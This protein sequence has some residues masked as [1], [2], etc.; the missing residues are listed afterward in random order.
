MFRSE[1]EQAM[2]KDQPHR[3]EYPHIV[4]RGYGGS[5]R[6]STLIHDR[7]LAAYETPYAFIGKA[8]VN[9]DGTPTEAGRTA[10]MERVATQAAA[11]RA[12]LAIVW[13]ASA[14]TYILPDGTRREGRRPPKGVVVVDDFEDG[15]PLLHVE[16]LWAL[17]LPAGSLHDHLCLK[18]TGDLVEIAPGEPMVVADF[19]DGP[20]PG[21]SSP[22]AGMRRH[23]GRLDL[24]KVYRGVRVTGVRNGVVLLGPVQMVRGDA[25]HVLH[26][27]WPETVE[28]VCQDIAGRSL[29]QHLLDA[30]WRA[31]DPLDQTL[32]YVGVLEAA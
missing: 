1:P 3:R 22:V 30:A 8:L 25:H 6:W 16:D 29:P 10:I 27:P 2:K 28:E 5:L 11:T 31:V 14:C 4:S 9:V 23:D 24:P 7:P 19:I 13:S 26:D 12:P 21:R 15:L 18:R 17:R 20:G 32:N